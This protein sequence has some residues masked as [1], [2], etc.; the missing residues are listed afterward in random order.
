MNREE[1]EELKG[2]AASMGLY[3]DKKP[4]KRAVILGKAIKA[5]E[6]E[7][8]KDEVIL[9]KEEY[10]ELVSSEF[11]NGYAKGFREALEQE[12]C[13]DFIS[14]ADVIDR[15][16]TYFDHIK[17]DNDEWSKGYE[18]GAEDAISVIKSMPSVTPQEP[19]TGH[20]EQYGNS[21]EDKFKCSE[22]GKEQPKILCGER[23]IGHWSDYCPN[24][25]CRMVEPQESEEE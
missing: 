11:D 25:G 2:L 16:I 8:R 17:K 18:A 4:C 1:M 15:V 10:G 24:C 13:E 23:I 21:W 22:C 20:W 9:T 12:P 7:P 5:L 6:Q 19:K 3:D 14:R